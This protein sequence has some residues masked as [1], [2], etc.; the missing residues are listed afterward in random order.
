MVGQETSEQRGN[1]KY[2]TAIFIES[3][4]GSRVEVRKVKVRH[5]FEIFLVR[6]LPAIAYRM[7]GCLYG[8]LI[9]PKKSFSQYGEDL[10]IE[11]YFH[12]IN[13]NRG[14]YVDVGAFHPRWLSNSYLLAQAGW[15]G[16]VVDLDEHKIKLFTQ[17]RSHCTGIVAAVFPSGGRSEETVYKFA[18]LW[19]EI[20]TLSLSDAQRYSKET[21]IPFHTS[22]VKTIHL[23]DVLKQATESYGTVRFLNIDIE[24]LDEA[25]LREMDLVR[26]PVDLICFENN[27]VLGGSSEV[28]GF[29]ESHQYTHL[30]STGGSHG[31]VRKN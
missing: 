8:F 13:L 6:L 1:P 11:S 31:Y 26:F 2:A 27:H 20:D 28:R 16:T 7:L 15:S 22:Q 18:R 29:L 5:K 24:G 17:L 19:S 30:F 4:Y 14:T 25:I 23:N 12:S 10:I 21:G 3:K 9:P